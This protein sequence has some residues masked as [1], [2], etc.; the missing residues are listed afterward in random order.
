ML[1]VQVYTQLGQCQLAAGDEEGSNLGCPSPIPRPRCFSQIRV[2]HYLC[3]LPIPST[4]APLKKARILFFSAPSWPGSA[5]APACNVTVCGCAHAPDVSRAF[6]GGICTVQCI[7]WY[8]SRVPR[9]FRYVESSLCRPV[10]VP[11]LS[12]CVLHPGQVGGWL[13]CTFNILKINS[14]PSLI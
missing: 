8:D 12:A 1:L 13:Q 11:I 6:P 4:S 5:L 7:S 14:T 2:S 9:T 10:R 3:F